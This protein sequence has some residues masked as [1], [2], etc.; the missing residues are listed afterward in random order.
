MNSALPRYHTTVGAVSLVVGPAF[1]SIGDL[2][3]PAESWVAETQV[4]I[5]APATTRWYLAHLLLLIGMLLFIPGLLAMT[6]V[7]R[8]RKVGAS[9]AARV[10][11][12]VGVGALC[13]VFVGEM[14]LGRFVARANDQALG[15]AFLEMFMSPAIFGALGPALL[16]FFVGTGILVKLLSSPADPFRWPALLFGLGALLIFGEIASAQV[17]LSQIGN[18]VIFIAGVAFYRQMSMIRRVA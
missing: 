3:H 9:Y 5:L 10:L 16:A 6:R 12:L 18:V 13:A 2:I 7:A 17:L 15:I 14:M 1:M 11:M 8:D 4:A